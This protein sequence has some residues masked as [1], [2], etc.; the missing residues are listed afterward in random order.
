MSGEASVGKYEVAIV[1]DSSDSRRYNIVYLSGSANSDDWVAGELKGTLRLTGDP[2]R[3]LVSWYNANK[4]EGGI[5]ANLTQQGYI[6]F[7]FGPETIERYVRTYPTSLPRVKSDAPKTAVVPEEQNEHETELVS[8]S[9]FM[10]SSDGY[11]VTNAHVVNN[12]SAIRVMLAETNGKT[13]Y[14]AKAV[15]VDKSNDLAVLVITDSA[16]TPRPV[17]PF[18]MRRS[19]A[20]TG[21]KVFTMGYPMVNY[22][23][24]D[25]KVTDGIVSSTS[26]YGGDVTAYQISAPI[27]QGCSGSPLFDKDGNVVGVINALISAGVVENVGYAVKS[28]YLLNLLDMFPTR[29]WEDN[30]GKLKGM[31]LPFQV[32]ALQPYIALIF[33]L[34]P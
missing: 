22:M 19:L 25:V 9:G 7:E 18:V 8:G 28:S 20:Q 1:P 12:A 6:D 16:F 13:M 26:G 30:S 15:Q 21:E 5:Y 17:P 4:T 2:S 31:S 33:V 11:V 23:G 27:Q 10:I 34:R 3:Y 14:R 32:H 29:T 24:E